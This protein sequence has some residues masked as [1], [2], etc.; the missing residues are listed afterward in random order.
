[1]SVASEITR[2]KNCVSAAYEELAK[3][4]D[5]TPKIKNVANL[6]NMIYSVETVDKYPLPYYQK[7]V[8]KR[9]GAVDHYFPTVHNGFLEQSNNGLNILERVDGEVQPSNTL[10]AQALSVVAPYNVSEFFQNIN[11]VN[12][13]GFA[14]M[15]NDYFPIQYVVGNSK[16]L[17]SLTFE[18]LASVGEYGFY[19]AFMNNSISALICP[20]LTNVEPFGFKFAFYTGTASTSLRLIDFTWLDTINYGCFPASNYSNL[21]ILMSNTLYVN[22]Y[23]EFVNNHKYIKYDDS[24]NYV[25]VDFDFWPFDMNLASSV[26]FSNGSMLSQPEVGE[27]IVNANSLSTAFNNIFDINWFSK[28]DYVKFN[29]LHSISATAATNWFKY[30]YRNSSNIIRNNVISYIC[31][32]DL[33]HIGNYG[34]YK[35]ANSISKPDAAPGLDVR[36]DSLTSIDSYGLDSAFSGNN[37]LTSI[38]FPELRE[39][40]GSQGMYCCCLACDNLREVT[41]YNLS[42]VGESGLRS[43]FKNC[44]NLDTVNDLYELTYVEN[45][46]MAECFLSCSLRDNGLLDFQS[47]LSVGNYAF[48]SCFRY[49]QYVN[50]VQFD[51]LHTAGQYAFNLCFANSGIQYAYFNSLSSINTNTFREA[52]ANSDLIEISFNE[53]QNAP[54]QSFYYAFQ[55]CANLTSIYFPKL[56]SCTNTTFSSNTSYQAFRNC[57]NLTEI[58]FRSDMEAIISGFGGY[59]SKFGATNATIYFDL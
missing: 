7:G 47:L 55:N 15:F 52:F 48:Q 10:T 53:L 39:I 41:F 40:N 17:N 44:I 28:L 31:F 12:E 8:I 32:S 46:G 49:T 56:T 33:E 27:V 11:T 45:Y 6:S 34:L 25:D 51:N 36:F 14:Y 1:M 58:H 2:I 19:K 4:T 42:S 43:A 30:F 54:A 57:T 35:F 18:N 20:E 26:A 9:I 50:D 59:T 29:N 21:S 38:Y 16:N 22:S 37:R 3:K 23:S 13:Y 5:W 24:I